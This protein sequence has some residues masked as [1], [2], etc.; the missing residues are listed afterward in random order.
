MAERTR[1]DW[2]TPE[3]APH[4]SVVDVGGTSIACPTI[5]VTY[6][7]VVG[8]TSVACPIIYTTYT[9]VVG[10]TSVACMPDNLRYIYTVVVAGTSVTC[11]TIYTTHTVVG[12]WYERRMHAQQFT[13]HI[14][15]GCWWYERRM[16][17]NL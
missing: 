16:P 10:G 2:G 6:T 8:G 17:D 12:W 14:H 1:A 5:Y 15:G 7:V 9:V 4:R 3:R 11:P 13:L